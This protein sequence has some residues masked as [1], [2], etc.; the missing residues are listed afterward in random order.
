MIPKVAK[1]DLFQEQVKE[2]G[3]CPTGLNCTLPVFSFGRGCR[4][5]DKRE[6]F[7][8]LLCARP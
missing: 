5:A 8:E 6:L 4:H 7:I 3:G 2:A 1:P